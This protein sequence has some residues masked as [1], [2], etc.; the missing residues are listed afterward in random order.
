MQ[1]LRDKAEQV[2]SQL[3]ILHDSYDTTLT[4]PKYESFDSNI[5][6]LN[7]RYIFGTFKNKLDLD[8]IKKSDQED[9]FYYISRIEPYYLGAAYI[10]VVV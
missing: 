1:N 6:D 2:K 9:T 7:K 8:A 3:R 5:Y 10:L 4:Y